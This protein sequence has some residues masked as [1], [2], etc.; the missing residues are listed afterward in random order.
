MKLG[1]G[2]VDTGLTIEKTL[3]NGEVITIQKPFDV[4]NGDPDAIAA[5]DKQRVGIYKEI[6]RRKGVSNDNQKDNS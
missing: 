4:E 1:K 3:S 5:F 6:V 2:E